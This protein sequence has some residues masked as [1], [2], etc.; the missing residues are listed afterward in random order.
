MNRSLVRMIWLLFV[1]LPLS[2]SAQ[3]IP[4]CL[5]DNRNVF[6]GDT[7]GDSACDFN[8]LQ[9]AI[10]S[11]YTNAECHLTIHV[12]RERTYTNQHLI[13][14]N[15]RNVALAGW[16]DG[17]TCAAIRSACSIAEGCPLPPAA[18][19]PLVTI[20]GLA[21]NSVIHIDG[22]ESNVSLL[23]LTITGGSVGADQ[24]G[25][26]I[27]YIGHGSLSLTST[28]VNLNHAG[29]GAG[30]SMTGSGGQASLYLNAYSQ[31]LVNTAA[32]SGGGIRLDGNARMYAL[33]PHTL[34]GF[35]HAP[36]GYGGGIEVLG[37][38]R[39]DIGS[40]GFN[41]L[42]V[43][44][45]ND[46][47][48]GGGIDI[49]T[50]NGG[51]DAV[52]RLFTT[53]PNNPVQISDN[54][55]S[56]TGGAVYLRPLYDLFSQA[57]A[58]LCAYDFR[59]NGNVA[60]E[61]AAIY[62]DAD[63]TVDSAHGGLI[64]LNKND[65]AVSSCVTPEAPSALGAVACAANVPC[66]EFVGNKAAD[67]S[68]QPTAGS[69]ILLQSGSDLDG[70]R[71][72]MRA[73]TGGHLLREIGDVYSSTTGATFSNCLLVDNSVT[74]E[75]AAQTDGN[76]AFVELA[77]CT[78]AGN[79]IGA[80]NAFNASGS[81]FLFDTIIDQPGHSTTNPSITNPNFVTHV[82]TNDRSTLPDSV[83][84]HQG[85]PTFVDAAHGDYHLMPTSLGVDNAPIETGFIATT[86]D[87]DRKPRV[88]DLPTVANNF[89]PMDLGAYEVRL[90]AVLSCAVDDTIFCNGFEGP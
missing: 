36:N 48:Y 27:Y 88:V 7:A 49:L 24:N 73:N 86:L 18:S 81:F 75:L 6:V 16:G 64:V 72:R 9:S 77:S 68:N 5:N 53:D 58:E 4:F 35:N 42:G 2:A 59:I 85:A 61:G 62:S 50:F 25:G 31:I 19:N 87:L 14:N 38:A 54:F 90:Q 47:Q 63:Y 33:Q 41:G 43:I 13:V 12:T 78:V 83:Y 79:Q 20:S 66:N 44:H 3:I 15:H 89:G 56:H 52:V 11:A 10:D 32:V 80:L 70:D 57:Q 67:Q 55:A 1:L 65:S 51:A 40:S 29:Y 74:Q 8:D 84:V 23:N 17:A 45:G 76:S 30:I 37:P 26:G 71:L 22:G 39:A 60:P 69:T 34:I 21:G 82:L 28:T 46:A